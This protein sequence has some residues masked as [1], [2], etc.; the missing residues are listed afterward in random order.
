MGK[1]VRTVANTGEIRGVMSD[2][3][4]LPLASAGSKDRWQLEPPS[5]RMGEY[6]I[7]HG[8]AEHQ[9]LIQRYNRSSHTMSTVYPATLLEF[10]ST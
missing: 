4:T 8:Q 9:L 5:S 2:D 6:Q 1:R 3:A 10:L 7:W